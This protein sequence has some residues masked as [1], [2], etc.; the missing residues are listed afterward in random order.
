MHCL[1]KPQTSSELRRRLVDRAKG[2]T[3]AA[4][5]TE[6]ALRAGELVAKEAAMSCSSF[7]EWPWLGSVMG[8]TTLLLRLRVEPLDFGFRCGQR[9]MPADKVDYVA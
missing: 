2:L 3:M 4:A 8:R 9:V 1:R 7:A 6:E 5:F